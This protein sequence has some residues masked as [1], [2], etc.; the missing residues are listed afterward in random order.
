MK[1][2]KN[3]QGFSP[4]CRR[5]RRALFS[6]AVLLLLVLVLLLLVFPRKEYVALSTLLAI[7]FWLALAAVIVCTTLAVRNKKKP[8]R[9]RPLKKN[10]THLKGDY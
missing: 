3:N 1:N 9:G 6:V 5:W 4:F 2:R 8:L 10:K 7:L